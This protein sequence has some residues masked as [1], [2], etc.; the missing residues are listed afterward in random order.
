MEASSVMRACLERVIQKRANDGD[1]ESFLNCDWDKYPDFAPFDVYLYPVVVLASMLLTKAESMLQ[2][3]QFLS[4]PLIQ[5]GVV[6]LGNEVQQTMEDI[7]AYFNDALEV[8]YQAAPHYR[9]L[10]ITSS[11]DLSEMPMEDSVDSSQVYEERVTLDSWMRQVEH[12]DS[13]DVPDVSILKESMLN[14]IHLNKVNNGEN[15]DLKAAASAASKI[16]KSNYDISL[17]SKT[18]EVQQI[19]EA[20][21][22]GGSYQV[23]N[24]SKSSNKQRLFNEKSVYK[25]VAH[26]QSSIM[27]EVTPILELFGRDDISA[28]IQWALSLSAGMSMGVLW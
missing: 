26:D 15:D 14:F 8:L 4:G 28:W 2:S 3:T 17:S 24:S 13:H 10:N 19:P 23:S 9:K 18:G 12:N 1:D 11:L 21:F 22:K 25:A 5:S 7:H 27:A 20:Y 6:N 16:L